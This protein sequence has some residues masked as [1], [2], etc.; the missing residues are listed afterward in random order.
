MSRYAS[1]GGEAFTDQHLTPRARWLALWLCDLVNPALSRASRDASADL[2]L[3]EL[4]DHWTADECLHEAVRVRQELGAK[5]SHG[6]WLRAM[7][8]L[9][10][11]QER[12]PPRPSQHLTEASRAMMQQR[13]RELLASLTAPA[14]TPKD[15]W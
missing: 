2:L 15:E 4:P 9:V 5:A 14:P 12:L 11:T 10:G 13:V 1:S 7:G 8:W 6:A 3:R